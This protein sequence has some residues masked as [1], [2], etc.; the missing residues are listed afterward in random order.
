MDKLFTEEMLYILYN[1]KVNY[2]PYLLIC[3]NRKQTEGLPLEY[4]ENWEIHFFTYIF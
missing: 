4:A 3:S 1:E 2:E